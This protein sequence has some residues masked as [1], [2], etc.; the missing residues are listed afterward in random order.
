MWILHSAIDR[1]ALRAANLKEIKIPYPSFTADQSMQDFSTPL[2][3]ATQ[4]LMIYKIR[5]GME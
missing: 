4:L 1:H 5:I 3:H 2:S